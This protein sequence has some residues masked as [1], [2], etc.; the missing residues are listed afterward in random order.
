[1]QKLFAGDIF[2]IFMGS[3]SVV[4]SYYKGKIDEENMYVGYKMFS[5]DNQTVT[6][7]PSNVYLLSK[8]GSNYTECMPYVENYIKS[9]VI[10]LNEGKI[11]ICN[12][13]GKSYLLDGKG[14]L[15][16]SGE[17]K[18]KGEPPTFI[19]LYKNAFW[20]CFNS[21][22]TVL[23][24]NP[25]TLREELRVGGKGSPLQSPR[26]IF[27]DEDNFYISSLGG[28]KVIK[29]NP[30]TFETEDYLY[31]D[32]SVYGFVKAGDKQFAFLESGLYLV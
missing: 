10:L 2:E 13:N 32:E 14:N 29:L 26:H 12:E 5:F 27:A 11:F 18:Y 24:L 4:F 19:T 8:F 16:W 25:K 30:E 20:A 28:K 1:M 22:D 23:R 21:L 15:T 17:I 6:E 3:S 9:T 7:V 31:F